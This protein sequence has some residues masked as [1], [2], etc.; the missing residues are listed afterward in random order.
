MESNPILLI[1][2]DIQLKLGKAYVLERYVG[3]SMIT[4]FPIYWFAKAI[5]EIGYIE[6]IIDHPSMEVRFF[7]GSCVNGALDEFNCG[8]QYD[9]N[10][11]EF[12]CDLV[13]EKIK[14]VA[15][16]IH[17]K[18]IEITTSYTQR[19]HKN[20]ERDGFPQETGKGTSP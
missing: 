8:H 9:L 13:V 19:R 5:K 2:N 14:T 17:H 11:P 16:Y 6:F 7:H 10:D 15:S 3:N 12:D 18:T 4:Y 1:I 20:G